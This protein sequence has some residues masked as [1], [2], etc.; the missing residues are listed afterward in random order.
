VVDS[1]W[2]TNHFDLPKEIYA[3]AAEACQAEIDAFPYVKKSRYFYH[4][5]A[6]WYW[7][8][9]EKA[10]AIEAEQ[11]AIESLK[12]EGNAKQEDLTSYQLRL[13]QYKNM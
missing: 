5:M 11:T 13:R 12:S 7:R 8:A 9:N 10:K 6:D 1:Y 2:Y 3:L 4:K